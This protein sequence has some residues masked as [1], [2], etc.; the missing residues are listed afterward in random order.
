MGA[1][2]YVPENAFDKT[3][4]KYRKLNSDK[5]ITQD[6][7][8][9]MELQDAFGLRNELFKYIISQSKGQNILYLVPGFGRQEGNQEHFVAS[10]IDL[11]K[12]MINAG[13]DILKAED[14]QIAVNGMA[15]TFNQYRAK[16]GK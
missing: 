11:N 6:E 16:N 8:S 5:P 1:T 12:C 15:I 14:S 10:G 7:I 2:A 4:L 3:I 13:S 9:D